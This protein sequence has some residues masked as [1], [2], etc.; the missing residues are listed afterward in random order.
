MRSRRPAKLEARHIKSALSMDESFSDEWS[1]LM[2]S[3]SSAEVLDHL[4]QRFADL[5][6]KNKARFINQV[7]VE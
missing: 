5:F 2:D 7:V 4:N 6:E 1:K 3:H